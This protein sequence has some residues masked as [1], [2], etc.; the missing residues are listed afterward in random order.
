MNEHCAISFP[1]IYPVCPISIDHARMYVIG[2][3]YA[4]YYK[5]YNK[6]IIFPVG[7]HYSG[8]TSHKFYT[9]LN[10]EEENDVKRIFREVY[11]CHPYVIS[12]LKQSPCNI[13]DYFAFLTLQDFK[14]INIAADYAEYYTTYSPLYNLFVCSFFKVYKTKKV[15]VKKEDNIQLDYNNKEWKK[16]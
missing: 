6:K 14:R 2:D 9:A 16:R 10:S 15:L 3:V 13:L 4:R 5:S 12:Y 1:C 8:L 7:F 11:Q